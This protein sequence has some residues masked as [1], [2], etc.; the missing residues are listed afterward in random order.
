MAKKR[1][2]KKAIPNAQEPQKPKSF[3]QILIGTVIL[4][5]IL[6]IGFLGIN[7]WNNRSVDIEGVERTYEIVRQHQEDLAYDPN[8]PP[9]GGAHSSTWQNCGIYVLP[10]GTGNVLHSL[11]HGA[12]W[13]TYQPN[14]APDDVEFLRRITRGSGKRI[15]SPYPGQADVVVVS[16][17][18]YRL[19]VDSARDARIEQFARTFEDAGDAPEPGAVCSRGTG[20]PIP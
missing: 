14:L 9:A 8:L 11:E 18:G 10:I 1:T 5:T 12:V 2:I 3:D 6:I 16:S 13:I 20:Q 19:Q 17:W 7:A 15:L 4:A